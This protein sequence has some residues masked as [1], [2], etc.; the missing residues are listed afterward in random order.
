MSSLRLSPR[1]RKILDTVVGQE[2]TTT[3]EPHTAQRLEATLRAGQILAVVGCLVLLTVHFFNAFALD[4]S[5]P[6]LDANHEGTP[7][8]WASAMATAAV[9]VA[10]LLA[11]IVTG[12]FAR[13]LGLGLATAFLSMDDMIALHE[14]AAGMLVVQFGVTDAW[15]SALWPIAYLPLVAVTAVLILRMARSGTSNTFRDASIGLGFLVTALA[16]E[17]LTS[18]WS[19]GNNLMHT[20]EGGIEEALELAG[21]VLIAS[22]TLVAMLA[23]VVRQAASFA[24]TR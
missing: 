2:P 12:P 9:A 5:V 4:Y 17:A 22:S 23:N 1:A 14:R 7:L 19:V 3:V 20:V 13:L 18:P 16:L 11:A 6:G 21:W 24:D 10:A 8:T 15:G